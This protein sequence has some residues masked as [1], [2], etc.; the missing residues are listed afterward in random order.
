VNRHVVAFL[1]APLIVPLVMSALAIQILLE[2]PSLYW[3]GLLVALIVSY[4]G[5]LLIGA[6][7]Y[8][9]L[10]SRSWSA[11]WL[12]PIVGLVAGVI[13][14]MALV[15][16]FSLALKSETVLSVVARIA[17]AAHWGEVFIVG[18]GAAAVVVGPSILGALVGTVLWLIGRPDRP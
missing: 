1:I 10:R 17:N 6:P 9:M 4:A 13:V 2:V 8:M 14:A 12:A 16:I 3:F 5:V 11:F 7:A 15:L 18:P